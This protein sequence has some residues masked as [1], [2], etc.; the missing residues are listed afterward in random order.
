MTTSAEVKR[1]QLGTAVY[2]LAG[3][4]EEGSLV[5]QYDPNTRQEIAEVLELMLAKVGGLPENVPDN[6]VQAAVVRAIV[7]AAENLHVDEALEKEVFLNRQMREVEAFAS[8]HGHVL[9]GWEPVSGEEGVEYQ[10]SCQE[11]GGFVYVS[12]SG[13]YNLLLDSCERL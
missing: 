5:P 10:V 2:Y 7:G 3:L 8:I 13:T 11:C 9:T 4:L 12:L 6:L 1:T